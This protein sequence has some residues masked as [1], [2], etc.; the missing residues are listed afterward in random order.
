MPT[1]EVKRP[2]LPE[3]LT[4]E[5]LDNLPEELAAQIELWDG[6]VV[7]TDRGP[8]EH[9][10]YTG[11]FWSAL[12]RNARD[13]MARR[14]GHC[15]QVSMETNIFLKTYDKSD[16]VTPD[17]LIFRCLESEYQD[18]HASD[19][20]LAGEVLSPSNTKTDIEAKKIRY[21]GSGIPW[22]WEVHLARNP[23]RIAT[24]R[25]YV[26]ETAPGQIHEG[27]RPLH[28]TNYLLADEW[29]PANTTA[30]EIE[31]P[32]PISIPWAELEF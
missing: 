13:D 23:R 29:T 31:H 30:I 25:A 15:W 27:V 32:F 6:R 8:F 14:T 28:Q 5:Q 2:D 16:F 4:W 12:R 20:L 19:V 9:Q 21:A 7:W 17:F 10:Q 26:L 24:V 3:Y 11:T 22:Y 1:T 18:V